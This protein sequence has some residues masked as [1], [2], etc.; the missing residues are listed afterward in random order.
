MTTLIFLLALWAVVAAGLWVLQ[1]D[2]AR[3]CIDIDWRDR[4]AALCW[5]PL[6]IGFAAWNLLCRV[7][8]GL[9]GPGETRP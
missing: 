2:A 9:F 8:D 6:L 3:G 5:L 4:M 1:S 7:H